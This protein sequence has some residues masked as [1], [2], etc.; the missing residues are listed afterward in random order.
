MQNTRNTQ[1]KKIERPIFKYLKYLAVYILLGY[2]FFNLLS[3]I[4]P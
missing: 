3:V 2:V 1:T 4:T